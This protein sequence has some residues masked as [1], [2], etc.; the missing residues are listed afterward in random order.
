MFTEMIKAFVIGVIQGVTEWL[1]ISSTGHMLLFDL[2]CPSGL[3]GRTLTLFLTLIQLF[4]AVAVAVYERR[5]LFPA[6]LRTGGELRRC[7]GLY[8]RLA[9]GSLPLAAVGFVLEDAIDA[10]VTGDAVAPVIAGALIFYGAAFI[11][12]ELLLPKRGRIFDLDGI[13][14]GTSLAIGAFQAL[15]IVPGTS[16]SG[17]TVL[18][19][20]LLGVDRAV[21]AEFSFLLSVPAMLGASALRLFDFLTDGGGAS[22]GVG[23]LAV[24]AV[25]CLT[26]FAVSLVTVRAL[27]EF[28]RRHGFIPFGIYRIA[29]GLLIIILV[30]IL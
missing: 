27:R 7:L 3:D 16:R 13:G 1:P 2:I 14:Y 5:R 29:L 10:L 17:A 22:V 4:S 15:A 30:S 21:A 24:I 19:A 11:L 26:A 28:L 6:S 20:R 12:A 9:V 23:E 8:G 25:G 18:G